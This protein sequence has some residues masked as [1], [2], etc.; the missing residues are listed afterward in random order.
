MFCDCLN[1][2]YLYVYHYMTTCIRV[3]VN[4]IK[5]LNMCT[6]YMYLCIKYYEF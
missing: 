2:R 1:M 5:I 3:S 4:T 6:F